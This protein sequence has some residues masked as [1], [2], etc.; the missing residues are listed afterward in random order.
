M[1][2]KKEVGIRSPRAQIILDYSVK[3]EGSF[4]YMYITS[5]A[6][7]HVFTDSVIFQQCGHPGVMFTFQKK[8]IILF[9]F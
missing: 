5:R 4:I 3:N 7:L 9:K 2:L 6:G 8:L 1:I